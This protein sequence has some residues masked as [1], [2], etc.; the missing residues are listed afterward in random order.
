MNRLMIIGGA[1]LV[2]LVLVGVLAWFAAAGRCATKETK[3]ISA[4]T[5][6]ANK[7]RA[8]I[9]EKNTEIRK[10]ENASIKEIIKI[11]YIKTD[12]GVCPL[13]AYVELQRD[14]YQASAETPVQ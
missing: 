3:A 4:A 1:W 14:I 5:E 6:E 10:D 8:A 7:D 2:S 13:S 12:P 9:T 11:K